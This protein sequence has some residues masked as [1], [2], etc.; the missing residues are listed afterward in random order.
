MSIIRLNS[1]VKKVGVLEIDIYDMECPYCLAERRYR[2][3]NKD[4]PSVA[5]CKCCKKDFII[6]YYFYE[7]HDYNELIILKC[8]ECNKHSSYAQI[9]YDDDKCRCGSEVFETV[10]ID[11]NGNELK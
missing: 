8:K 6:N 10:Q 2:F 7:E 9:E 4:L 5:K 11:L 1:F 3:N